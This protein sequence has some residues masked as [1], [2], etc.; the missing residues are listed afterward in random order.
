MMAPNTATPSKTRRTTTS[1][2]AFVD[3]PDHATPHRRA[4]PGQRATTS[5]PE[6]PLSATTSPSCADVAFR[7][8]TRSH[9]RRRP[10]VARTGRTRSGRATLAPRPGRAPGGRVLRG[11]AGELRRAA[12][13]APTSRSA[14]A[15]SERRTKPT[16]RGCR[17]PDQRRDE[18]RGPS[19]ESH[20]RLPSSVASRWSVLT[21]AHLR[22]R[23]TPCIAG[24]RLSS[25]RSVR[26]FAPD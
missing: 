25:R 22:P 13:L 4:R 11:R 15:D 18:Q 1:F 14:R 12:V 2:I 21:A 9:D 8:T 20:H 19:S 7:P 17:R 26:R 10:V 5:R 24:R 3:V 6:A 23:T 16:R